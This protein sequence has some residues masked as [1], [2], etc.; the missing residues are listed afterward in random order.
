MMVMEYYEKKKIN[1]IADSLHLHFVCERITLTHRH[2][3]TRL[4]GF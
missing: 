2:K 3:R 1:L 4:I